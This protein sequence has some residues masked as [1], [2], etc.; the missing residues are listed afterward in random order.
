MAERKRFFKDVCAIEFTL[1]D[2]N[3]GNIFKWKKAPNNIDSARRVLN[4]KG[5]KL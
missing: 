2:G 4:Q 5:I 3:G 1:F